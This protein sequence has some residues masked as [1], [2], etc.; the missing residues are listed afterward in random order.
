MDWLE[1]GDAIVSDR[2]AGKLVLF[3]P[4]DTLGTD[5]CNVPETYTFL[6]SG[7]RDVLVVNNDQAEWVYFSYD[8][9]RDVDSTSTLVVERAILAR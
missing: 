8:R 2:K 3:H 4:N 1:N 7:M 9:F 6:D 5:I